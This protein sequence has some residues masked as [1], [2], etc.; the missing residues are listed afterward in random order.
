M[1]SLTTSNKYFLYSNPTDMRKSFDALSGLVSSQ[2]LKNPTSGEVYIFINKQR[3]RIKL[4]HW[5]TG[6]FTLYYK[7]LETGTLELPEITKKTQTLQI[8]WTDLVLIIQG[9]S[10]KNILKKKRF[11]IKN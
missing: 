10:T 6:G 2:M 1:F 4:L 5:E 9:I 3:N 7:R 8:N 11:I